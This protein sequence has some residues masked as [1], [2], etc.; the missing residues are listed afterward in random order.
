MLHIATKIV[1]S[2]TDASLIRNADSW[3]L[4]Y[5][6]VIMLHVISYNFGHNYKRLYR[7]VAYN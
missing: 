3:I 6:D 4:N 5:H 2:K 7:T 1:E